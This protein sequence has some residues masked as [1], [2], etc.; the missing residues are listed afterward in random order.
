MIDTCFT[1]QRDIKVGIV[2]VKGKFIPERLKQYVHKATI[3]GSKE[4]KVKKVAVYR[5]TGAWQTL[6]LSSA[7]PEKDKTATGSYAII[8][9]I[10]EKAMSVPIHKIWITGEYVSGE[11]EIGIVD[12]LPLEGV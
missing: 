1:K 12:K 7:L 9:G 4:G 8:G 3:A 11:V 2:M 5:D 6:M 10:C